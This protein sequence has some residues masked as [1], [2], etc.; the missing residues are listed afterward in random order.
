MES[1]PRV[2]VYMPAPSPHMVGMLDALGRREDLDLRVTY[3]QKGFARRR[4]P[5]TPGQAPHNFLVGDK[6]RPSLWRRSRR[7]CG[8][9]RGDIPEVAVLATSYF[10][11][12]THILLGGL[13]RRGIPVAFFNEA[14]SPVSQWLVRLVRPYFL[15]RILASVAGLI[16]ITEKVVDVY[17]RDYGYQG[18]T[19]WAPYHRD[20][21]AFLALPLRESPPDV[22]RFVTLGELIERKANGVVIEAFADLHE[23]AEL[24]IVGDG[25][26]RAAL[27]AR[28]REL[29]LASVRFHGDVA[30]DLVPRVLAR[31]DCLVLASREDGFGMV[32]MEALAAGLP[33]I[34]SDK[35][36]S[37]LQ[38]VEPGKN[39][40]IFPVDDVQA[41]RGLMRK[42][43]DEKERWAEYSAASRASV[44]ENYDADADAA[45]VAGFLHRVVGGTA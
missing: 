20:L 23:E 34:A 26:N 2:H 13:S 14:P 7:A 18:P 12:V 33:V 8:A 43:V 3:I 42:V 19:T 45:R 38:Y 10:D 29:G 21:S 35:V 40:W 28:A 41:L 37:A 1:G 4:W 24:H 11:P 25:P 17:R 30:Y 36:M 9:A 22:I 39:G 32:I 31:M 6:E 15:R 5:S 16:G 44:L 27:E